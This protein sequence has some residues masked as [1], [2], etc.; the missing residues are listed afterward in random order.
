MSVSANI[1]VEKVLILC[2]MILVGYLLGKFRIISQTGKKEMTSVLFYIVT[3]CLIVSSLQSTI[4]QV[5]VA[6]L[7]SS[8]WLS[9]LAMLL[10]ILISAPF[11]R[12]CPPERGKVLRFA[13]AY[14]NCGFIG[15]PLAQAILGSRGA[16]YSSMFIAAFNLFVWTHGLTSMRQSRTVEPRKLL[17]NPGIIGLA[18]GFPLFAASIRLPEILSYPIRSFADL[19]TPLAMLV[20]GAYISD[21]PF[22]EIFND[23]DLYRMAAIRLLLIPAVCGALLLPTGID[24]TI[25]TTILIMCASPSGANTVMFSAQFGGDAQLA[26][27]AIALTTLLS[28]VTILPFAMAASII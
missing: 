12:R 27:K 25:V 18:I 14:S 13:S 20:V 23:P 2:L 21:V 5:S 11:F 1:I 24:R 7:A 9:L 22:R 19:N 6:Q 17:L 8:G 3:P 10:C 16:A 26:S 28:M 15:L 4:G